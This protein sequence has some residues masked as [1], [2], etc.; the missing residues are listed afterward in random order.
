ME[1]EGEGGQAGDN[2]PPRHSMVLSQCECVSRCVSLCARASLA[3]AEDAL[4]T[5]ALIGAA[6]SDEQPGLVILLLLLHAVR[7]ALGRL[8]TRVR[9]RRRLQT[10]LLLDHLHN[11]RTTRENALA[12]CGTSKKHVCINM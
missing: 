2:P 12:M 11:V 1:Q 4:L 10:Q 7:L 5:G 6:E 8:P 9:A 3:A